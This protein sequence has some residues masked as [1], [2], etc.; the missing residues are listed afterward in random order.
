MRRCIVFPDTFTVFFVIF[1]PKATNR[2]QKSSQNNKIIKCSNRLAGLTDLIVR[3]T[4]RQRFL[5]RSNMQVKTMSERHETPSVCTPNFSDSAMCL[6][7]N[8]GHI[9]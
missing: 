7:S 6:F 5:G 9:V 8:A 4:V 3:N 1:W 2:M